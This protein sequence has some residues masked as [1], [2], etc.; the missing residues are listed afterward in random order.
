M[1]RIHPGY[2][3]SCYH[4]LVF[5]VDIRHWHRFNVWSHSNII[6]LA[7]KYITRG[8]ITIIPNNGSDFKSEIDDKNQEIVRA[9]FLG[10]KNYA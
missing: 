1:P 4:I 9:V 7:M 8:D 5:L 10:A 3:K 2:P 6:L